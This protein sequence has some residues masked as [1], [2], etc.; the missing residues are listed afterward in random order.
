[1]PADSREQRRRD[2]RLSRNPEDRVCRVLGGVV[3]HLGAVVMTAVE[4]RATPD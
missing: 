3:R 4:G 2:G 1:M